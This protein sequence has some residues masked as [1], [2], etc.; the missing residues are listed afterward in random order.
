[1]SFL[2]RIE[3]DSRG[4]EGDKP[5]EQRDRNRPSDEASQ[6]ASM[7]KRREVYEPDPY[8]RIKRR[9]ANFLLAMDPTTPLSET[10]RLIRKKIADIVDEESLGLSSVERS[11][12]RGM[13]MFEVFG[14]GPLEPLLE[15][16]SISEIV[17]EGPEDVYIRHG[18]QLERAAVAFEDPDQLKQLID[19]TVESLGG[20]VDEDAPAVEGPLFRGLHASVAI[21]PVAEGQPILTVRKISDN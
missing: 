7:R 16:N 11:R 21:R 20:R 1:M 14:F 13:M 9:V 3:G 19:R 4:D 6:L 5:S 15:D 2:K 10:V 8:L 18:E 17:V 12:A